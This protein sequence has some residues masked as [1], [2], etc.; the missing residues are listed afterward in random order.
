MPWNP[1]QKCRLALEQRKLEEEYPKTDIKW[2]HPNDPMEDTKV[3]LRVTTNRDSVYRLRVHVLQD[4][5]NSVPALLVS[6]SPQPMPDWDDNLENHTHDRQEGLIRIC[7]NYYGHWSPQKSRIV[8][9]FKKGRQWLEAYE[10]SLE[11]G[12]PMNF[13]LDDALQVPGPEPPCALQ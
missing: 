12:R 7:Y 5:P 1:R 13:Y 9:V 6:E 11:T 10:S 4:F 3:E 2:I 8:D